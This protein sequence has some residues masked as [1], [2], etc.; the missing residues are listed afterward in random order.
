MLT[1]S[2]ERIAREA[3]IDAAVKE[4]AKFKTQERKKRKDEERRIERQKFEKSIALCPFCG[5]RND[6]IFINNGGAHSDYMICQFCGATGPAAT[7]EEDALEEWNMRRS[8]PQKK[9][10]KSHA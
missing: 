2:Q 7:G 5:T 4:A 3:R 10:E 8:S 9:S 6:I 1:T